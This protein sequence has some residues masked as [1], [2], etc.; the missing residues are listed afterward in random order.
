M[1]VVEVKSSNVNWAEPADVD[2]SQ[3]VALPPGSDPHGNHA[4]FADGSVRLVPK[5]V[6]PQQI[7]AM[8]T[9]NGSEPKVDLK[10]P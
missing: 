6:A 3:P 2:I 10:L 5:S 8:A 7:R 1:T 9:R 4:A